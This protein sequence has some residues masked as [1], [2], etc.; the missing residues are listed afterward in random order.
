M[1][2]KPSFCWLLS[3]AF[4]ADFR[5]TIKSPRTQWAA[6]EPIEVSSDLT[7]I[8]PSGEVI[9]SGSGGGV[10]AFAMEHLDGPLDQDAGFDADCA[11]HEYTTGVTQVVPFQK[12][13]GYTNDDPN[14]AFWQRFFRDP[15]LRLPGGHWRLSAVADFAEGADC[16]G[17]SRSIRASI[18]LVVRRP[19][20]GPRIHRGIS[21][22]HSPSSKQM[23][24]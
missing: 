18:D 24:W 20:T 23:H 1:I 12:S 3:W 16:T 22:T 13:G 7:Y 4:E 10:V 19:A 9:I 11:R 5:L 6:G 15:L 14:L 17:P 8:G 2:A 21:G